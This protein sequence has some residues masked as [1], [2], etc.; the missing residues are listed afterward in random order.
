M[1]SWNLEDWLED[2]LDDGLMEREGIF[3]HER[4]EGRRFI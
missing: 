2:W 3:C 4:L 1:V